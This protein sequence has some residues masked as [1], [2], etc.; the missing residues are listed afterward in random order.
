MNSKKLT[1]LI[2]LIETADISLQ[3]ARGVLKELGGEKMS[4]NLAQDRAKN[5]SFTEIDNTQII[6]GVFNGQNMIGPDGKKYSVPVNYASKSKLVEGDIL[7]LTIQAD[8]TFVY[9][10]IKPIS[11]QRL[12]GKLLIDEVTGQFSVLAED[13]K[14]YNVLTASVTYFKAKPNDD[15]IIIIPQDK[16][17]QWAAIENVISKSN[18]LI[19]EFDVVETVSQEA[20]TDE[21]TPVENAYTGISSSAEPESILPEVN[22]LKYSNPETQQAK[23]KTEEII[24]SIDLDIDDIKKGDLTEL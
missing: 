18:K 16:I 2:Q 7:K 9:K 11:R 13:K 1:Q 6:G 21:L 12:K 4:T 10:Q 14:K 23:E 5:L 8:G 24:N 19:P 3:Q 22:E 20:Q 15:L 17:C